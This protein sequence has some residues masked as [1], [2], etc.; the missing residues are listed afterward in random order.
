MVADKELIVVGLGDPVMDVLFTVSHDVLSTIAV[1]AGGCT[2]I[3][4]E[5]LLHLTAVGFQHCEPVR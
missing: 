2:N 1:R 5:E 3:D 4:H